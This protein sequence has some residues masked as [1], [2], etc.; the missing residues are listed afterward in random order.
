[1]GNMMGIISMRADKPSASRT[2]LRMFTDAEI[3]QEA[4]GIVRSAAEPVE[5]DELICA[6][7]RRSSQRLGISY[8][9]AKAYWYGER[10]KIAASELRNLQA[11][12]EQLS[13]QAEYRKAVLDDMDKAL[14]RAR[15]V[16]GESGAPD[17]SADTLFGAGVSQTV[18]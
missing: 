7:V 5:T 2:Q 17:G 14:G 3:T 13:E 6:R 15:R 12:F 9:K 11:R 4:R 8:S 18:G 10:K 1:M 16:I